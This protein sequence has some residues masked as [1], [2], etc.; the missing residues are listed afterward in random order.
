M[1]SW[2]LSFSR[3]YEK[4]MFLIIPSSLIIGFILSRWLMPFVSWSP[5][6]FGYVTFVMALGCGVEHLKWVVKRPAP[7]ILTIILSHGV[8]PLLAYGIGWLSFG[9]QS[10]YTVGLVLF[11]I[12]PLG[13]SSVLWVGMS[14]GHI[15]LMLAMVVLDSALSLVVVPGLI[16][17]FFSTQI[18]FDSM[19]LMKDLLVI[20]VLPTVIGVTLYEISRGK[21]KDKTAPVAIP[22]SKLGFTA[23]VMLNAAAIAPHVTQ[24]KRDMVIVI[25]SVVL[26]VG[27][28]YILG[29]YGSNI[30]SKPSREIKVTLSYASGMRNISLGMV[31]AM[32]YFSPKASVPVVLGIM[33]Q[34]PLATLFHACVKKWLPMNCVPQTPVKTIEMNNL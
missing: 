23:V 15:P 16:E 21:L 10:D 31:I 20:V 3:G 5:Y 34:Q 19:K 28:S 26:V 14:H 9:A 4:Y 6:I 30:L 13:V 11:T 24:L 1:R 32:T 8:A 18:T 12:I 33:V 25:P 22:L 17:A 2:G 7:M 29:F 27:L